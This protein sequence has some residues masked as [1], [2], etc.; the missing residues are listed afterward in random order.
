MMTVKYVYENLS[1]RQPL[2]KNKKLGHNKVTVFSR[3][4]LIFLWIKEY[5]E[6]H[7]CQ[8]AAGEKRYFV[9]QN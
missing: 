4:G 2:Q 8:F 3:F 5:F 1:I 6:I 7:I 9:N